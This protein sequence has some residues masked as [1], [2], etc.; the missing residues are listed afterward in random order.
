MNKKIII[1]A[2]VVAIIGSVLI[3]TLGS[4]PGDTPPSDVV[5]P[6]LEPKAALPETVNIGVLLSATGD[7]ASHGQDNNIATQLA[8]MDF[9]EYLDS[10]GATWKM[11]LVVEDTQTDPTVA[12]EKIQS[13]N[14]KG[15]KLILGTESSA[16]LRNIMSYAGSNSML[17][18]S[19]SS[20]SPKLALDDNI[21]RLI[22]DDTKQ[23][24]VLAELF[25]YHDVKV[26]IPVYRGDVWGD[27]LYE[28]TKAS[29]EEIGGTFDDG[30]RYS[31]DITV[32]ST[33]ASLL[34]DTVNKY[35]ESYPAEE[36]AVL[37]IGFSETV[38]F[39]NSAN[40]YDTLHN[41]RWFGSDAISNDDKI[42][43]DPI[44]SAFAQDTRL[45]SSQ[46]AASKNDKFARVQEYLIEQTGSTPNNYAY[47]AYDS[48]WVLGLTI[49]DTQSLDADIIKD[50]MPGVAS[51]YTGAIGNVIF[52]EVGDLA[53]SDYE[54]W[55]IDNAGAW[56]LYGRYDASTNT[57]TVF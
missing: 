55:Y 33:E 52:N 47:S 19:P 36:V 10:I 3:T 25:A 53:I 12:L 51:G 44:A 11:N 20:T 6:P 37:T 28:S 5:L 18:V 8:L 1:A 26:I 32:F 38:H 50:A 48:L 27:G 17:L 46:F 16:E 22:P 40:S 57:I 2:V 43:D 4:E 30:I 49:H 29:F 13:L 56:D 34:S 45:T 23:G 39:L 35:L 9:N 31:P 24:L 15:I 54:L 41:V 7:L 42:T 21:F 14:S